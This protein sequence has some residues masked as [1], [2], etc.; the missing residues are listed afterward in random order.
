MKTGVGAEMEMDSEL[1][2]ELEVGADIAPGRL[3]LVSIVSEVIE[4]YGEKFDAREL[5]VAS[6]AAL[7]NYVFAPDLNASVPEE[8]CCSRYANCFTNYGVAEALSH[9]TGWGIEEV[10][11]VSLAD[12]K[13]LVLFELTHGRPLL[14]YKIGA[15]FG[16][17]AI[18]ACSRD[19]LALELESVN[20]GGVQRFELN[21][22][23]LQLE[24]EVLKNY[25]VL[26]RPDD[27]TWHLPVARQRLAVLRW[28]HRHWNSQTEFFHTTMENYRVGLAATRTFAELISAMKTDS[29]RTYANDY[30]V[31]KR[32][33]FGAVE[34]VLSSWSGE[35]AKEVDDPAVEESLIEAS[36]RAGHIVDELSEFA[37]FDD[38]AWLSIAELESAWV[39]ALGE[40]VSSFPSI[41]G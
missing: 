8:R 3:G 15:E 25:L 22:D 26:I 24:D 38:V 7:A 14:T 20:A 37:N 33:S 41:Y 10:N 6:S 39:E 1:R 12:A 23:P 31:S 18:R 2:V 17:A 40:A 19:G 16:P 13:K 9:Y 30:F 5:S 34:E 32:L 11:G 35:L 28:A 4:L 29:Q 27:R 36:K 21:D